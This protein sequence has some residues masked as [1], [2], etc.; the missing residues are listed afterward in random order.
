M[1]DHLTQYA[2]EKVSVNGKNI[3]SIDLTLVIKFKILNGLHI[4]V[5][6]IWMFNVQ[7]C[8]VMSINQIFGDMQYDKVTCSGYDIGRISCMLF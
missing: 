5:H 6:M 7:S 8:L 4:D 3:S 1:L 2:F